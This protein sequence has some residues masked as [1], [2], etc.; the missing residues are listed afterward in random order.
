MS[1][2]E[3]TGFVFE[4]L[5]GYRKLKLEGTLEF[6]QAKF[7][8]EELEKILALDL[9]PLIVD[10]QLLMHLS[11]EWVRS[12]L[13]YQMALKNAKKG[14][15][16]ISVNQS[17]LSYLKKEGIDGAFQIAP[18]LTAAL[19]DLGVIAKRT[20]DTQF[21]DPFLTATLHV[22]EVQ[23]QVQ[24]KAGK[25]FLKKA[26]EQLVGDISGVIGVVSD[27]FNGSVVISFPEATFLKVMSGMLGEEITKM[28]KEIVDGAG[29]ITNMIFG[30]A[31]VVLNEKGYG[32]K[33]AIPSVVTG[34]G[35]SLN[36]MTKG[37]VVVVP[38]DSNVGKF[39]VEIGLSE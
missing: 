23:A 31:K 18:N 28:D 8:D 38:F 39:F 32:I 21:I 14:M 37:P 10:C 15:K 7:F 9:E 12:L 6:R 1:S 34:K 11:K 4:S 29:E 35:H 26:N 22:L 5:E 24:A 20:M 3:S 16:L 27:A 17:V 19:I 13:R 36:A 25:I 30:Q 33:M 2:S